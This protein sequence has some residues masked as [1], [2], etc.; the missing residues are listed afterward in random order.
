LRSL[1]P[2][3]RQL[4]F[5]V[6]FLGAV[7]PEDPY[8][9][10]FFKLLSERPWAKY[11]GFINREESRR[12]FGRASL[13]ALPTL[14]DNCPMAVLEA[15][16]AGVPVTASRVGGV[17]ELIN[18]GVTGLL[19]DPERPETFREA[20]RRLLTDPALR[21]RLRAAGRQ[22]ARN[23]FYPKVIAKQHLAI[24]RTLAGSSRKA[25]SVLPQPLAS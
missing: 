15:M 7:H 20:V 8:G 19:C 9:R 11:G 4:P 10:E 2:L 6:L 13:L 5:R 18:D 16:A 24:Y 25:G 21:L 3:A 1:D 23:R 12:A 17:P 14:E 22:S